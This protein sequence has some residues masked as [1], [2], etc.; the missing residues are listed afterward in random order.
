MQCVILAAGLG[1]RM[2]PLTDTIPKPL[3]MV[4]GRPLLSHIIDALPSSIDEII[5]VVGYKGEMIEAHYGSS[6]RGCR[7]T[8]VRQ[9]VQ[10]GTAGALELCK[11]ILRERFVVMFADDIHGTS[12]L[13]R[14][15]AAPE[16]AILAKEHA[17]PERFGVVSADASGNMTDIVEKPEVPPTNLVFTGPAI[18]PVSIFDYPIETQPNGER[19][20]TCAL[21]QYAHDHPVAVLVQELWIPVGYP[22]DVAVAEAMLCPR[23]D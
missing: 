2:R 10:N 18:L 16:A 3:V 22:Q 17:Y 13:T 20:L 9:E 8:Y 14:L 15:V 23:K 11:G 12:D 21:R 19:Y 7:I 4:C 1:T 6:Y 5:L